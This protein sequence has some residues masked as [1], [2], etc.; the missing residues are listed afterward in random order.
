LL[1]GVHGRRSRVLRDHRRHS[2]WPGGVS[3]RIRHPRTVRQGAGR[4]AERRFAD[5]FDWKHPVAAP[6][7]LGYRALA[8]V[9]GGRARPDDH[10]AALR[11]AARQADPA[12][13]AAVRSDAPL[14]PFR[15]GRVLGGART[16]RLY[17]L[18]YIAALAA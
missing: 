7:W 17:S 11:Q 14:T 3:H 16:F 2:V 1:A 6:V 13:P 18:I 8:P 15:V 4:A 12:R 9:L 10:R 5:A